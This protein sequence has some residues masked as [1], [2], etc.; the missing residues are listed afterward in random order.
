MGFASEFVRLLQ[1]LPYWHACAVKRLSRSFNDLHGAARC[2]VHK[3]AS[4][5]AFILAVHQLKQ[6]LSGFDLGFGRYTQP[7]E[8]GFFL[9]LNFL[10]SRVIYSIFHVALLKVHELSCSGEEFFSLVDAPDIWKNVA[11]VRVQETH[12]VAVGLLSLLSKF[13]FF[14]LLEGRKFQR[15]DVVDDLLGF[16]AFFVGLFLVFGNRPEG[17]IFILD[18]PAHILGLFFFL[19]FQGKGPF[20]MKKKGH[21]YKKISSIM[22]I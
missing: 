12:G 19:I 8:V 11:L 5:L 15:F 21:Y 7:M 20:S 2:V 3:I 10:H 22:F 4:R 18:V 6:I 17:H 16:I 9:P 1:G 14:D 13:H